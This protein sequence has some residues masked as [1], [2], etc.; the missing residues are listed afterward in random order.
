MTK[1]SVSG[2]EFDLDQS[3]VVRRD[4]FSMDTLA[5][6]AWLRVGDATWEIRNGA[7]EGK[8]DCAGQEKHGQLFTQET[9]TGDLLLEFDAATVPPSDHDIIWW[10]K[11][12][13]NPDRTHWE[14]GYLGGLAG[15]Y[16]GKAGIEKAPDFKLVA[17]TA[18]ADFTPGRLYRIQSGS[19]GAQH[20]MFVDGKLV[21]E[22][23]DPQPPAPNTP[24]RI[25]FGVYQS[26]IQIRNLTV[27]RIHA[28]KITETYR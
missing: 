6:G 3:E 9:F 23:F 26:Q 13:L 18:L 5:A 12:V 15:W 11:T 24:A 1:L 2:A 14:S 20:F 27:S 8:W 17:L 21:L 4:D 22:L 10:W 19:I 25:G 28:E 7:L 16:T